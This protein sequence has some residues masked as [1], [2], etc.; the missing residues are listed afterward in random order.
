VY[1]EISSANKTPLGATS[2][3]LLCGGRVAG[4]KTS[5]S[6]GYFEF[7]FKRPSKPVQCWAQDATGA[8]S[9]RVRVR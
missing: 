7:K 1:G 5:D 9:R 2:I 4:T 3:N 6:D 8:T